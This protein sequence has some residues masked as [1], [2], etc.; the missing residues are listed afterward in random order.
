MPCRA[1]RTVQQVD[2]LCLA[3]VM[4]FCVLSACA[5]P[6]GK[7]GSKI[8]F[9]EG[10]GFTIT[11]QARFDSGV[12]GDFKKALRLIEEKQY[13]LGIELLEQVIEAAPTSTAAHIDLGIAYRLRGDYEQAEASIGRALELSPRHPVAHNEIGIVRRKMGRFDDARSSYETA[14][15]I[16]PDFH[17]AR[18]NLAI[19]CDV[20]VGDMACAIEHYEIYSKAVP[21]DEKVVMWISDLQN[22]LGR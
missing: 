5:T 19:L 16:S 6:S 11:E 18:R 21:D 2:A 22:R 17:F 14:L 13:D 20:Y 9:Q 15:A 12:R 7:S 1:S 4:A 3:A 10:G 8:E